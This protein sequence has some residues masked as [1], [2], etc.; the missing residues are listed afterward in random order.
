MVDLDNNNK[1]F[2]LLSNTSNRN[3]LRPL[4]GFR[5]SLTEKIETNQCV[6]EGGDVVDRVLPAYQSCSFGLTEKDYARN[7]Y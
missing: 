6:F 5:R 2:D 4:A 3:V 7:D 1:S